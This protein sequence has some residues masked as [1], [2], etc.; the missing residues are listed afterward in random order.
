MIKDKN[1]KLENNSPS[2]STLGISTDSFNHKA[3]SKKLANFIEKTNDHAS[4]GP[5]L[6]DITPVCGAETLP[7][8]SK[9][10]FYQG[11]SKKY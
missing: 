6:V 4:Q 8:F 5:I 11:E 9:I 3:F 10:G 7:I 1:N 2:S